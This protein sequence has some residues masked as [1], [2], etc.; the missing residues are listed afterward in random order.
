MDEQNSTST[1]MQR[2]ELTKPQIYEIMFEE[3]AKM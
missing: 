3:F 2:I 1:N